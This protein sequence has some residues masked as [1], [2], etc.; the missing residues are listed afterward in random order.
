MIHPTKAIWTLVLFSLSGTC[1]GDDSLM[2][3]TM[4]PLEAPRRIT[5]APGLPGQCT[6]LIW[7]TQLQWDSLWQEHYTYLPDGSVLETMHDDFGTHSFIPTSWFI[8]TYDSEGRISTETVKT[9]SGGTYENQTL[10]QWL[11]DQE[12]RDSLYFLFQ[13]VNTPFGWAWD[14]LVGAKWAYSSAGGWDN[15]DQYGW[16]LGTSGGYWSHQARSASHYTPAQEIDSV[17][18]Y[19]TFSG[20][21]SPLF[22]YIDIVWDDF[23]ADRVSSYR[24]QLYGIPWR[25]SKLW[26]NVF[27]GNDRTT[28]MQEYNNGW[29]SARIELWTYDA[30]SLPLLHEMYQPTGLDSAWILYSGERYT[31]TKDSAGNLTQT[32]MEEFNQLAGYTNAMRYIYGDHITARAEPALATIGLSLYPNPASTE[33]NLQLHSPETGAMEF[34]LYDMNGRMRLASKTANAR[35]ELNFMLDPSMA[36]GM[37]RY[38]VTTHRGSAT[39]NLMITR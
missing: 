27:I 34:K 22:R 23:E 5:T 8:N 33:V 17:V 32:L 39:G 14:T 37:Y 1:W 19:S 31:H 15:T 13:W 26:S 36:S 24:E 16:I 30:D 28:Y 10:E 4:D 2:A 25:D 29:D 7:Q 12:D 21:L 11:Y 38:L 3:Q 18:F 9:W 20:S 35:G 6:A